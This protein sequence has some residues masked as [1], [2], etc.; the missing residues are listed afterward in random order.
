M[1]TPV[2][3]F[4]EPKEPSQRQWRERQGGHDFIRVYLDEVDQRISEADE[5]AWVTSTAG[6]HPGLAI[7]AAHPDDS[8]AILTSVDCENDSG[9]GKSWK[10]TATFSVPD[11][12]SLS[13]D[14]LSRPV[15]V[16]WTTSVSTE[17][18]F[19]DMSGTP[20]EIVN[21][22]GLPFDALPTRDVA[23]PVVKFV[24]NE[25]VSFFRTTVVPLMG[26]YG[27]VVNSG[28]FT[29]DG[30]SVG[31][32]RARLRV[33]SADRQT[34]GAT[35]FYRVTYVVEL[36][37]GPPGYESDGW[38]EYY[39]DRGHYQLAGDGT[40]EPIRDADGQIVQE[41]YPLDGSGHAQAHPDDAPAELGPFL[42]YSEVSFSALSFS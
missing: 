42:P 10:I 8:Y 14:P 24:R 2:H 27:F 39:L 13:P 25:T 17:P 40:I 34:E 18:F 3:S 23:Y 12:G 11:Y 22:A 31:A 9:D 21:S 7:G 38:R 4:T 16:N 29:I 41:A 30:I 6:G 37:N 36:R 20:K 1:P 19:K 35:T 15:E 33:E 28:S 5:R 32:K 26:S